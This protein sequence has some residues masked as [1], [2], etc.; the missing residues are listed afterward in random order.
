MLSFGLLFFCFALCHGYSVLPGVLPL[1]SVHSAHSAIV[2]PHSYYHG[3]TTPALLSHGGFAP[4][5]HHL[6]KRSPHYAP[7]AHVAPLP[8]VATVEHGV[9]VA[10]SHQQ[11]VDIR[12]SPAVVAAP[13]VTVVKPVLTSFVPATPFIHKPL[14]GGYEAGH[15]A[16][17][18]PHLSHY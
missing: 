1:P 5:S 14:I 8:H 18:Y 9:P 3:H 4:V 12:S 16:S 6:Y 13:V 15:Y 17:V 11:R 10:V 2:A 7:I